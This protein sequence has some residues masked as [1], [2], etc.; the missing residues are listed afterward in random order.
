M[1]L[2]TLGVLVNPPSDRGELA[3]DHGMGL[4]RTIRH[5]NGVETDM[6]STRAFKNWKQIAKQLSG[7][8]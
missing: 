4:L 3:Q 5:Q 7:Y 2:G 8:D 6:I 1:D